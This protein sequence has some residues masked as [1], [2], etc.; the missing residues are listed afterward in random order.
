MP[1]ERLLAIFLLVSPAAAVAAKWR[2][3]KATSDRESDSALAAGFAHRGHPGHYGDGASA[4]APWRDQPAVARS[5]EEFLRHARN[6]LGGVRRGEVGVAL[7]HGEGLVAQGGGELR[8]RRA[9]HR[10]VGGQCMTDVVEMEILDIALAQGLLPGF[11]REGRLAGA[12]PGGGAGRRTGGRGR[13]APGAC[14]AGRVAPG[15]DA[16]G[17]GAV[18]G[19]ARGAGLA[20]AAAEG[21]ADRGGRRRAVR[22]MGSVGGAGGG[23]AA[24]ARPA[25]GR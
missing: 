20:A 9:G 24:G 14:R 5:R 15:G 6:D 23:S 10:Q 16:R 11:A 19:G 18:R 17:G 22:V 7:D 13:R 8:E 25:S 1:P 12:R 21:G 4:S 3:A 2:G